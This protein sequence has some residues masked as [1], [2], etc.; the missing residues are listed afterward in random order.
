MAEAQFRLIF[1]WSVAAD[2]YT[3]LSTTPPGEQKEGLFLS[4]AAPTGSPVR[5]RRYFPFEETGMFRDFAATSPDR[6]S[7]KAFA[8]R[9]GLLGGAKMGT[10]LP[11]PDRPRENGFL[12]GSG[13]RLSH[14]RHEIQRLRRSVELYD[15]TRADDLEALERVV[16][17]ED[18]R[19]SYQSHPD[20]SAGQEIPSDRPMTFS[21]IA[22]RH[23]HDDRLQRFDH[24]DL[25]KPALFYIQKEIN[26]R[27]NDETRLRLLWDPDEAQLTNCAV[28]S[29][30]LG[31]IWLQFALSVERGSSFRRCQECSKWFEVSPKAGRS[32]KLFCSTVCRVKAFRKRKAGVPVSLGA[33]EGIVEDTGPDSPPAPVRKG[34]KSRK[35][36][37]PAGSGS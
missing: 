37:R 16:I 5:M 9:Y 25:I 36:R 24:G 19:V 30:L 11:L 4:T 34:L 7:I 28:P 29:S 17:W 10:L 2:G 20:W 33:D 14:W 12:T 13:E 22:S 35:G 1:Q 15:W 21:T 3:W 31:A 23:I 27:L 18:D 6:E 26:E 32:D 8:D